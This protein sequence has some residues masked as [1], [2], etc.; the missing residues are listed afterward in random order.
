MTQLPTAVWNAVEEHMHCRSVLDGEEV[1]LDDE[2]DEVRV[3]W[4]LH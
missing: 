2:D 4:G 3:G 1:S